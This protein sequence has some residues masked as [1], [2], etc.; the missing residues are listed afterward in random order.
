MTRP[1]QIALVAIFFT[2]LWLPLAD[3]LLHLDRSRPSDE[4]RS[5][6]PAPRLALTEQALKEFPR[7][8][9]A[10]YDDRFGFR[11]FLVRQFHTVN[12]GWLGIADPEKVVKGKEGWLYLGRK[13]LIDESRGLNPLKEDEVHAWATKIDAIRQW[14][15]ARG[16]SFLFVLVPDKQRVF[17]EYLPD[18]YVPSESRRKE[19]LL[20]ALAPMGTP[21]LDLTESLREAKKTGD[22][23]VWLKTDTHWSG[24]GAW[25]G[26]RAILER[27]QQAI[28]GLQPLERSAITR[29]GEPGLGAEAWRSTSDLAGLLGVRDLAPEPWVGLLPAAPRA[30]ASQDIPAPTRNVGGVN[31]PYAT[32]IDDPGLP[33]ALVI[34][35]SFR[36]ALV[37]LL[38]EH[39]RRALYT[40]FRYCFF[41]P[42]LADAEH[43]DVILFV[44]TEQQ[45]VWFPQPPAETTW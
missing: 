8:F 4:N 29:T 38:S 39:F 25:H 37:P 30:R 7:S 12:F 19:Q 40:D 5:L 17:P 44:L 43:P 23:P 41:D 1:F 18:W 35:G 20:Q 14:Q 13:V 11:N 26:Y 22:D 9:E 3:N 2:L 36:W 15:E 16:G 31:V 42:A 33:T 34:G 24:V 10:F 32:A 21:V 28:P 27:L 45:L 6:S